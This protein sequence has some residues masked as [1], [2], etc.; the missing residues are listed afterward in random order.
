M[1]NASGAVTLAARYTPWGDTLETRWVEPVETYGTGSFQFGYFGGVMDAATGLLYVGNGQYYDPATGRFLTRDARPNQGNPYTPFDP[2]GALFAPLGLVALVYGRRRKGSKGAIL[3]VIL[4][5]AVVTGMTLS[6]CDFSAQG[7]ATQISGPT[8][9][10]VLTGT[11]TANGNTYTGSIFMPTQTATSTPAPSETPSDPCSEYLNT[12]TI[13]SDRLVAARIFYEGASTFY[14]SPNDAP[15]PEV[16]ILFVRMVYAVKSLYEAQANDIGYAEFT[17][18]HPEDGGR[19]LLSIADPNGTHSDLQNEKTFSGSTL[20]KNLPDWAV[21]LTN[22]ILSETPCPGAPSNPFASVSEP[23]HWL[24][25]TEFPRH[26]VYQGG[27]GNYMIPMPGVF[28]CDTGEGCQHNDIRQLQH[29]M[30]A[31]GMLQGMEIDEFIPFYNEYYANFY[32]VKNNQSL[33][34]YWRG[35]YFIPE[36]NFTHAYSS[37][38]AQDWPDPDNLHAMDDGDSDTFADDYANG[39]FLCPAGR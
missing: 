37:P 8:P 26:D 22:A 7:T 3:L 29:M 21:K 11:A 14:R 13:P 6:G 1:T 35:V 33:E 4:S 15:P 30:D 23:I 17:K 25:P 27:N 20:D 16:N 24:S 9:G 39:K 38:D 28:G 10:W 31:E 36:S 18:Y 19:K 5:F 34:C 32:P 2:M 12:I